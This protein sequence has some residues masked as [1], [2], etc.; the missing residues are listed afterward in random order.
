MKPSYLFALLASQA[1][2]VL[3]FEVSP[4]VVAKCLALAPED[5]PR[6]DTECGEHPDV[7]EN[8]F[9]YQEN[10]LEKRD[11]WYGRNAGCSKTG[12]CFHTCGNPSNGRWCWMAHSAGTGPWLSCGNDRDCINAEATKNVGCGTRKD[13]FSTDCDGCG[14]SC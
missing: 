8:P 1:L 14:C 2:N 6:N 11:C 13:G 9:R 12:W 4:K 5:N 10:T 3:A 7:L